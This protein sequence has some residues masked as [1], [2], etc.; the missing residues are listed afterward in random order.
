MRTYAVGDPRTD[1]YLLKTE[2]AM[3]AARALSARRVLLR[4]GRLPRRKTR[5]WLGA[6]LL[7][8]GH[9]LLQSA[10]EARDLGVE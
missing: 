6:V 9:R 7:A 10:P 5:A 1:A 4:D 8:L 3:A 2:E